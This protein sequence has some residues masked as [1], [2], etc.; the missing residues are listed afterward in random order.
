MSKR[1]SALLVPALWLLSVCAWGQ[2]PPPP[3]PQIY[4]TTLNGNQVQ[5]VDG[6]NATTTTIYSDTSGEGFNFLPEGI[7][8]GADG[9]LYVANTQN[10]KILRM[11]QDGSQ[12]E[13][14]YDQS[15]CGEGCPF[16]PEGPVIDASGN[17]FFNTASDHTGVWE[18]AGV[19]SIVFG[20][21]F[22][23]PTNV[24]TA[25]QTNST[26]GEGLAFGGTFPVIGRLTSP[27]ERGAKRRSVATAFESVFPTIGG[28]LATAGPIGGLLFPP[29]AAPALPAGDPNL[30][31]VDQSNNQI[32]IW[33]GTNVA[34]LITATQSG[35]CSP[36]CIDV[37]IG[38]AVAPAPNAAGNIAAGDIFVANTGESTRNVNQFSST[39]AFKARYASGFVPP[40]DCGAD[41]PVFLAIDPQGNLFVT[42]SENTFSGARGNVWEV[43]STLSG[44]IVST[45]KTDLTRNTSPGVFAFG[46]TLGLISLPLN[47]NGGT[48]IYNFGP[49]N[50]KFMYPAE[51]SLG[52]ETLTVEA[53]LT[54]QAQLTAQTNTEGNSCGGALIVP[55]GGADGEGVT[56]S[57]TCSPI[58]CATLAMNNPVTYEFLTSYNTP[59][60]GALPNNPGLLKKEDNETTYCTGQ[61]PPVEGN[62]IDNFYVMRIDPT[63]SGR[64][65]PGFSQFILVDLPPSP[66]TAATFNGFLPPL[67]SRNG[68]VF[69]SGDTLA[70]KFSLTPTNKTQFDPTQVVARISIEMTST[71]QGTPAANFKAIPNN[72]FTFLKGT[73]QFYLNLQGYAPGNYLL[74][75]TSNSF[76]T[77]QVTFTIQ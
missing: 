35:L 38:I 31:I 61:A 29:R 3:V 9:K 60:G 62:I 15:T 72:N 13:T 52:G 41:S 68:R 73:F 2:S 54:T 75:V 37:P 53:L 57:T 55:Y 6:N 30:L 76:P 26:F 11:N 28:L 25:A 50:A 56:F 43:T 42:T 48:N 70:V 40:C 1:T 10:S 63:G 32:L 67:A 17:L 5:S 12:V 47:S 71:P 69:K 22:P 44:E 21:P 66:T 49:F 20:G 14:I 19:T 46:I 51:A 58:N 23:A 34:T 27:G 77:Q 8:L 59:P 65:K 36:T 45:T 39:G 7:T 64:T 4:I 24:V 18:I 16:S 33:D 74:I